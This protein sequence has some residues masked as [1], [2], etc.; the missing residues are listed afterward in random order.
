V[1]AA[2]HSGSLNTGR[3]PIPPSQT[4]AIAKQRFGRVPVGEPDATM[5][6]GNSAVM[7]KVNWPRV[8]LSGIVAGIVWIILGAVVTALLGR[9]FAALPGNHLG[10]PTPWFILFSIIIDLLEGI[11]ILW[12]YAAIRPL[13]GRAT[14][15]A[16]VAAFAW[17]FI[18][19][20]GDATWCSFG[21]FPPRTV[22]PLM[23]GTLP[24]LILAT[25]AGARFYKE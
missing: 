15:T 1:R 11:S 10:R 3:E 12:L 24:A 16:I 2:P 21:F 7:S 8:L 18:V 14:K 19:S 22:I 9:D 4:R 6:V 17:W 25:I 5:R 20:L 13:Y 23:A